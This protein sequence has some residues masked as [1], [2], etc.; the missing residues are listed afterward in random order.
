MQSTLTMLRELRSAHPAALE[1]SRVPM[2]NELIVRLPGS[3]VW[4]GLR[5]V[6]ALGINVAM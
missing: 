3:K 4:C 2:F 5:E 1:T 6:R